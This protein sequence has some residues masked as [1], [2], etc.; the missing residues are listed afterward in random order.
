[1]LLDNIV[2]A[3]AVREELLEARDTCSGATARNRGDI[4]PLLYHDYLD[5]KKK[6]G[7]EAANSMELRR[8]WGGTWKSSRVRR[9]TTDGSAGMQ[10]ADGVC[11]CRVISMTYI[12]IGSSPEFCQGCS[13]RTHRSGCTRIPPV[14]PSMATLSTPPTVISTPSTLS[15]LPLDECPTSSRR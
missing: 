12:H 5:L 3:I 6:P 13:R 10:L 7:V 8:S 14:S 15:S 1:M 4:T 11:M 9:G 2:Y